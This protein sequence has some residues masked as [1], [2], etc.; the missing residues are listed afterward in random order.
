MN[1][2]SRNESTTSATNHSPLDLVAHLTL[3]LSETF[4]AF[5]DALDA[6]SDQGAAP[7]AE[8]S[9][10]SGA[11]E[12]GDM[13]TL[14]RHYPDVHPPLAKQITRFQE[15]VTEA[16]DGEV[17]PNQY[18]RLHTH[19]DILAKQ[20]HRLHLETIA[21]APETAPSDLE[22]STARQHAA[23]VAGIANTLRRILAQSR[24]Q[25]PHNLDR[26]RANA[27]ATR[28]PASTRPT[29]ATTSA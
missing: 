8:R 4:N 5:A 13:A 1:S 22:L 26:S 16:R 15:V 23:A 2:Q 17:Q 21:I 19:T 9:G 25:T 18:D 14:P 11:N 7:S 24:V 10:E 27:T 20:A 29:S 28:S 12:R 6:S 3:S